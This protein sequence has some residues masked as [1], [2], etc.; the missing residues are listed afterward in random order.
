MRSS[1]EMSSFGI[2]TRKESDSDVV[3]HLRKRWSIF[4][5]V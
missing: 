2:W 1:G 4:I 5:V 3:V